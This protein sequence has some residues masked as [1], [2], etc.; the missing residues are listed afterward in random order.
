[1]KINDFCARK[2]I[3]QQ[4]FNDAVQLCPWIPLGGQSW[5]IAGGN[6]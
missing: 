3:L 1:M 5:A 2:L 6:Q 4:D